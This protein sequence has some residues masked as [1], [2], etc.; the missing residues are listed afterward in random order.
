MNKFN[1]L[2]I[3]FKDNVFEFIDCHI[4]VEL[5]IFRIYLVILEKQKTGK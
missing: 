3:V 1:L 4:F 2:I 5:E